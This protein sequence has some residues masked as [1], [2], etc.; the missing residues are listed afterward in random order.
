MCAGISEEDFV[1][2]SRSGSYGRVSC[3]SG[4]GVKDSQMSL[5]RS[6]LW[7]Q[8]HHLKPKVGKHRVYMS[9]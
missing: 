1:S 3:A 6:R 5:A 4:D 8:L 9:F 2:G 7:S